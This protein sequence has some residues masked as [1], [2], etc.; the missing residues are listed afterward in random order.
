MNK[1]TR[2][3]FLTIL[4]YIALL[5]WFMTQFMESKE[6]I[7]LI[8]MVFTSLV[9]FVVAH[10]RERQWIAV[11]KPVIAVI[12]EVTAHSHRVPSYYRYQVEYEHGGTAY[13][14]TYEAK[15]SS[16]V[17]S[18]VPLLMHPMRPNDV[19]GPSEKWM[20]SIVWGVLAG[21]GLFV[22]C[23]AFYMA[24]TFSNKEFRTLLTPKN[25]QFY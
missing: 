7:W 9:G 2:I 21:A 19:R 5:V 8:P 12:R 25:T 17:G 16:Q 18:L 10:W 23:F 24:I 14:H 15:S 4:V 1:R 13:T 3:L 20:H 6:E 22:A 11:A